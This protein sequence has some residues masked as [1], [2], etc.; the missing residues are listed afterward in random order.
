MALKSKTHKGLKR[1]RDLTILLTLVAG[2][3]LFFIIGGWKLAAAYGVLWFNNI[4][5]ELFYAKSGANAFVYVEFVTI[6]TI[7]VGM[8]YSLSTAFFFS[9]FVPLALTS[10]RMFIAPTDIGSFFL[11][12]FANF[13]D[14][15]VAVIAH[16]LRNQG[17][18][19]IMVV[20]LLIKHSLSLKSE[21]F[22]ELQK[23]YLKLNIL[24]QI[25]FN[26]LLAYYLNDWILFRV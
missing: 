10:I 21:K 14:A 16:L 22:T 9:L 19:T 15:F 4:L 3:L 25:V 17:L 26:L 1:N 11:P 18:F 12:S 13:L 5:L 20:V 6:T 23:P 8:H 2:L 24:L 7:F